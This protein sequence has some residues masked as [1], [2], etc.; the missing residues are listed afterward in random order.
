MGKDKDNKKEIKW[1][2]LSDLIDD[3]LYNAGT[4][5]ELTITPSIRDKEILANIRKNIPNKKDRMSILKMLDEYN[6]DKHWESLPNPIVKEFNSQ[7][8]A[9][10]FWD[11]NPLLNGHERTYGNTIIAEAF[12]K[13]RPDKYSYKYD[14]NEMA[15][16]LSDIYRLSGRPK[17][18][19][20]P[21]ISAKL[22][23][24]FGL[25][26]HTA[27]YRAHMY[28]ITNKLYNINSYRDFMAELAHSYNNHQVG[29]FNQGL[30]K[31]ALLHPKT[32][33]EPYSAEHTTHTYTEPILRNY[34][35]PEEITDYGVSDIKDAP[36]FI[37]EL[38]K[39]DRKEILGF[40]N[41]G[42]INE[43]LFK[44]TNFGLTPNIVKGGYQNPVGDG[45]FQMHSFKKKTDD[46]YIGG[47]L[48]NNNKKSANGSIH[49][50]NTQGLAVDDNELVREKNGFIEVLS[51][52]LK[53]PNKQSPVGIYQG[54]VN[55]G[56]RP[57]IA[58]NNAFDIQ[59]RYKDFKGMNNNRTHAKLGVKERFRQLGQSFGNWINPI[60]IPNYNEEYDAETLLRNR[61]RREENNKYNPLSGYN[62]VTKTWKSHK[63]PEGGKDTIGYGF[64]LG[65]DKE[66]D[67]L[68]EQQGYLTDQQVEDK[69]TQNVIKYLSSAK[70]YYNQQGG[71]FDSLNPMYQSILGDIHY[72]SGL[73][74]FPKLIEAIKNN[75][76]NDIKKEVGR[77]YHDES[78]EF[79]PLTNRNNRL[80]EE[81]DNY[82]NYITSRNKQKLGGKTPINNM[83]KDRINKA[84]IPTGSRNGFKDGGSQDMTFTPRKNF[85]WQNAK[86]NINRGWQAIKNNDFVNTLIP[87][88]DV[89]SGNTLAALPYVTGIG[90]V[91]RAVNIV[92]NKGNNSPTAR[93][94]RAFYHNDAEISD[95]GKPYV[96]LQNGKLKQIPK[97][98]LEEFYRDRN[99]YEYLKNRGLLT[100]EEMK[101]YDKAKQQWIE[102]S[103]DMFTEWI[104]GS[105]YYPDE[106]VYMPEVVGSND[107][108]RGDLPKPLITNEDISRK[109]INKDGSITYIPLSLDGKYK[110]GGKY[111]FK[112]G[113]RIKAFLG[114][115]LPWVTGGLELLNTAVQAGIAGSNYR[116]TKKMYDNLRRTPTNIP[117]V[118][119]HINTNVD[120]NPQLNAIERNRFITNRYIN[121]NSNSSKVGI[122]RLKN[123]NEQS[124]GKTNEM[125]T[126][127]TNTENTLKGQEA[128]LQA[129][130]NHNEYQQ[131]INNLNEQN[132]FNMQKEIGINNAR[133]NM[134][135]TIGQSVA[136]GINTIGNSLLASAQMNN[137]LLSSNNPVA[138]LQGIKRKYGYMYDKD[139]ILRNLYRNSGL[140]ST[141]KGLIGN[142]QNMPI[143]IKQ[144]NPTS[145]PTL[146]YQYNPNLNYH[147]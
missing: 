78:G 68:Y 72:T 91:N 92:R 110:N 106:N 95:I 75:N 19:N 81:I 9:N 30:F 100:K 8:E 79:H 60:E 107:F 119:E 73:S 32:Y 16:K 5:P 123:V 37:R 25:D 129:T 62:F 35:N 128:Q 63:S 64:K 7:E 86:D 52:D 82:N 103:N 130:Q 49:S 56:L 142:T 93:L 133:T 67:D 85:F 76:I 134:S 127:K 34:V 20:K 111:K 4:L 77:G 33:Q 36:D 140:P 97:S 141:M 61:L 89:T 117:L 46:I 116:K 70:E 58:F 23:G 10:K 118:R 83:Y 139:G 114:E 28:P 42:F 135:N 53:L 13:D 65:I 41:G 31:H 39:R 146:S 69:L 57:A 96:R 122:N 2:D 124:L 14:L 6:T 22:L 45:I 98:H 84:N 29:F 112:N 55:S 120:V 21:S 15:N 138:Q 121:A 12:T 1:L 132:D 51:N 115:Y 74:K 101:N 59:E 88:A 50:A 27:T 47:N 80:R 90:Q 43:P 143:I 66:L 38:V 136:S 131:F 18:T 147:D 104:E 108:I 26:G 125:L 87:L 48:I 54:L 145:F 105:R 94:M 17:F 99:D 24:I 113:G 71:D 11:E 40:K 3:N 109:I 44:L 102:D 144:N 137:D 126:Y